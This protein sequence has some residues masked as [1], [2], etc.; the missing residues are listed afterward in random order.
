M[1]ADTS[2]DQ[3]GLRIRSL[4]CEYELTPREVEVFDLLD[5][6]RSIPYVLSLIHI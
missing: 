2:T 5:R 4:A 6:G 3:L 1:P